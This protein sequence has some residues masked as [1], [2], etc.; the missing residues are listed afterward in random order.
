MWK[1]VSVA[2]GLV[3]LALA[4]LAGGTVP[5]LDLGA[6]LRYYRIVDLSHRVWP[7][8]PVWP[9]DPQVQLVPVATF[10]REGYY[11]NQLCIGEHTSTHINVPASFVPGGRDMASFSVQQLVL[12]AVVIDV[13][14]KCEYNADFTLSIEDVL[15]WEVQHG[16]IP[17]GSLVLLCTG[18]DR[19]W[20]SEKLYNFDENGLMHFPGFSGEVVRWLFLERNIAGIGIDTLGVDPGYDQE[21]RANY[22]TA[23]AGGFAL[24][25]LTNLG[26]LPPRG[27]V[28]IIGALAIQ[29]GSGS[30][31]RVVALVPVD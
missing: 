16:V 28:V 19:F 22:E 24:E 11:L 30:P 3:G 12:S 2:F 27:A 21:F 6:I 9:G 5:S 7:G 8:M 25:L 23:L 15:A 14:D 18:W 20:G 17:S 29:A 31:A 13:R 1:R 4:A 10:E 26:E